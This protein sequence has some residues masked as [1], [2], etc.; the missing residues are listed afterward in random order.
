MVADPQDTNVIL[1]LAK[2]HH[3][4]DELVEATAYHRR[5]VEV[6]RAS[7]RP[8]TEYAHSSLYVAQHL[9]END[10]DLHLAREYLERLAESNTEEVSK[11]SEMLKILKTVIAS[12][13]LQQR[14]SEGAQGEISSD[15]G[16]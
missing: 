11:A 2:L 13:Q 12:K 7:A 9:M 1:R 3:D 5:V 8:I 16:Y 14:D 6:C 15:M 4:L 10:G